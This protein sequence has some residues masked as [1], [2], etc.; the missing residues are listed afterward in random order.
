MLFRSKEEVDE[1]VILTR[2]RERKTITLTALLPVKFTFPSKYSV[3]KALKKHNALPQKPSKPKRQKIRYDK[4][5]IL[6]SV[7]SSQKSRFY[8]FLSLIFAFLSL[9]TPLKT[10]YLISLELRRD[11]RVTKGISGFLLCWPRE[12]QSSIR[13]SRESW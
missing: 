2:A 3:Y 10:Y 9:L 11:S 1:I 13:V 12:A 8:L 4:S 6:N 7:F 5:L